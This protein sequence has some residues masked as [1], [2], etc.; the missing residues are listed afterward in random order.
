MN[1]LSIK[2]LI[3][4]VLSTSFIDAKVVSYGTKNGDFLLLSIS[5]K[6]L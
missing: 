6:I 3:L 4:V 5:S 2:T 1:N